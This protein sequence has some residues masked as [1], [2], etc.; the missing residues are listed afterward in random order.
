[1]KK[2]QAFDLAATWSKDTEPVDSDGQK[3]NEQNDSRVNES[4][5]QLRPREES[6]AGSKLPT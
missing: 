5:W 6:S 2:T 3:T 1:M 4:R